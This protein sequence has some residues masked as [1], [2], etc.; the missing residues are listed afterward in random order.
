YDDW[1]NALEPEHLILNDL[2]LEVNGSLFQ[3]DSLVIFQ[4][5]IYLIDVKNHEGD[6][7]YDSSGK[8]WTIFGKEVKD[9]LLQLKRS[10]SLMRQLLHTLG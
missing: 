7:Y 1:M 5:M 4:D 2:L 3:V 6:Y 8:L 9:P 10:E